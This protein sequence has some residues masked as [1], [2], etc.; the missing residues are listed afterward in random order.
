MA[1]GRGIR[2][3]PDTIYECSIG[4]THIP[5]IR[6]STLS[7]KGRVIAADIIEIDDH[8]G[9]GR[10]PDDHPISPDWMGLRIGDE[11]GPGHRRSWDHLYVTGDLTGGDSLVQADR[12]GDRSLQ[13]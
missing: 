8:V 11:T 10:S 6:R 2:S 5:D 13:A 12:N 7:P 9:V 1:D 3:D 4:G